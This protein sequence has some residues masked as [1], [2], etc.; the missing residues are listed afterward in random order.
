MERIG[1]F[2]ACVAKF[3]DPLIKIKEGRYSEFKS[4]RN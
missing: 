1:Q 3:A 4:A 2:S